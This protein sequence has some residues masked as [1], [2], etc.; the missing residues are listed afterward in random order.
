M[1]PAHKGYAVSSSLSRQPRQVAVIIHVFQFQRGKG[2]GFHSACRT[3]W[4]LVS[5]QQG[6]VGKPVAG[7]ASGGAEGMAELSK[8]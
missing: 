3:D 6:P 1:M 2:R 5:V 7:A 8:G 4:C